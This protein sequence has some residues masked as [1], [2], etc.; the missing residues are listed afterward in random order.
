MQLTDEELRLA[1]S[2][3]VALV[4]PSKYEGFGM[5]V[6]EAMACACPVITCANASIPEVAGEAAIY[7][8][9]DDVM[10]LADALC[11]VQ[12]PSVRNVLI[13]A[14]LAQTKKFSWSNMAKIVSTAL[15]DATLLSLNLRDINYIIFPDWTQ[16]EDELGLELQQVIQALATHPENEKITLIINAGNIATEDAEMFLSSVAMNLLMEDL[17]ITDT[18]DISLVAELGDMQWQSLLPRIYGRVILNNEDKS[19]LAKAPVSKLQSYSID[20]LINQL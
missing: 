20:S 11:E 7:V 16:P 18:I 15:I 6:I 17:D 2:G 5:P 13:N 1:Y 9:D 4:Y 10:G 8:H 14:G 12:K 3:A 19:A